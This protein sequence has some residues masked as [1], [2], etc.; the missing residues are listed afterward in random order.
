MANFLDP[1]ALPAYTDEDVNRFILLPL[2]TGDSDLSRFDVRMGIKSATAVQRFGQI[3]KITKA[4]VKGFSAGATTPI[5]ER[6]ISPKRLKAE[7]SEDG[8]NLEGKITEQFLNLSADEKDNLDGTQLKEILLNLHG[9]SIKA[10]IVRQVWLNDTGS[11]DADYNVYD[12][13]FARYA[14]NLPAGQ[15]IVFPAGALGT[16][17][18]QA[19]FE[20]TYN[21]AP[22]ELL[23]SVGAV[24]EVTGAVWDNYVETLE[25]RGTDQADLRLINGVQVGKWRGFDVIVHREWD[26][27]LAA[28]FVTTGDAHRIVFHQPKALMI[29]TDFEGTSNTKTWYNPDEQEYRFRT[30]YVMDTQNMSDELAVTNI[31]ALA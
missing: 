17:A 26:T 2:F 21:A 28:D 7:R 23:N 6:V 30:S 24:F 25:A 10:D 13:I 11:A 4:A 31:A 15:K 22:P 18:A 14:A 29:G 5:T 8:F 27:H 12:G 1:S 19:Q 9:V 16:D 3:Q 20:A